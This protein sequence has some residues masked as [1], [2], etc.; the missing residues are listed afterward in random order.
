MSDIKKSIEKEV[1]YLRA[2]EISDL[3]A[4]EKKGNLFLGSGFRQMLIVMTESYERVLKDL[5][6]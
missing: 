2:L 5:D 6:L 4:A 1:E 3:R